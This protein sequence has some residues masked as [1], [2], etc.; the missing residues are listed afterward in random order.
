MND[1]NFKFM[2]S[3]Q[4]LNTKINNLSLSFKNTH[5]QKC[6]NQVLNELEQNSINFKPHFW[7]SDEWFCPDGVKGVAIPFYL[8]DEN[9]MSLE[10][11][12]IGY[13]EGKTYKECLKLLRHEIGH[14]I[15][16]AYGLRRLKKRQEVFGKSSIPYPTKYDYTPFS[17][18][19]VK[20]LGD[21]YAQSHPTEDFAETFAVWLDPQSNWKSKYKGHGCLKKLEYIDFIMS[22]I[23]NQKPI[24]RK[25]EIV[26]DYKSL[27][28]TLRTY[29]NRK[30]KVYRIS[31]DSFW[32]HDLNKIFSKSKS[33]ALHGIK[34]ETLIIQYRKIIIDEV[35]EEIN[36]NRY[37]VKKMLDEMLKR[38]KELK[39]FINQKE[40]LTINTL[41]ET[42]IKRHKK[43]YKEQRHLI[44]L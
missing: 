17:R 27:N 6:I 20:H 31:N 11:S 1:L 33:L 34:A 21:G 39:L 23:R 22:E 15:D 24:I 36:C 10:Q 30:I 8:F 26:E 35:A 18:Q 42:L 40:I 14:A 16:N 9:L 12:M 2:S 13:V 3:D 19:Y 37:E 43:F 4:L 5:V 29:Y 7:I 25:K 32:D 44:A 28:K 41:C 38:V